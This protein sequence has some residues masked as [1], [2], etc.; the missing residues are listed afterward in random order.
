MIYHLSVVSGQDEGTRFR[1]DERSLIVGRSPSAGVVLHDESIGW[2]HI[3]LRVEG[4]RLLVQNLSARGTRVK[5]KRITDETRVGVQDE[6]ELT[7]S[8]RLRIESQRG[9]AG[10]SRIAAL[11]IILILVLALAGLAVMLLSGEGDGRRPPVTST[12]WRTAYQRLD[13]RLAQWTSR[14]SFPAEGLTLFRDGWRLEAADAKA[15]AN[16][17]WTVLLSMLLT[18]PSPAAD[19]GS[20]TMTE[21]A[22]KTRRSL[23]VVMGYDTK[24]ALDFA[25]QSDAS[26]ADALVWFVRY[27]QQATAANKED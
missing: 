15:A 22:G 10:S 12:H 16:A 11:T 14:E 3:S 17:R 8:C 4:D 9:G 23:E 20:Q 18:L 25:W 6:I 1:V 21:T 26:F 13:E 2:E 19:A 5:G 27:R 7:E 24:S